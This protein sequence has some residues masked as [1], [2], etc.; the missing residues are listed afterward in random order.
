MI[1]WI[2]TSERLPEDRTDVL[3]LDGNSVVTGWCRI[4]DADADDEPFVTWHSVY[5][6]VSAPAYWSPM[7]NM[8]A[9]Y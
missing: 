8:P 9:N 2:K 4:Y 3:I 7:P 1:E 6:R 5:G